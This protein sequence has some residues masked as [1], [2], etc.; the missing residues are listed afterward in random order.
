MLCTHAPAAVAK[1]SQTGT[2]AEHMEPN[3]VWGCIALAFM[4]VLWLL[5]LSQMRQ[6]YYNLF[7]AT[8]VISAIGV[9]IAVSLPFHRSQRVS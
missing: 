1:W 6:I 4:D 5:S 8:H 3:I 7:Y 2:I 9:L